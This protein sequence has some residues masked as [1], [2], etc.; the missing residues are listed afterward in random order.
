MHQNTV[1]H[2]YSHQKRHYKNIIEIVDT[3]YIPKDKAT[4][5]TLS[6][7]IVYK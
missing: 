2:G 4:I 3:L 5:V 7:Q 6:I 1:A